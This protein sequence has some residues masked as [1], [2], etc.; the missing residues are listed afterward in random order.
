LHFQFYAVFCVF[1]EFDGLDI[2]RIVYMIDLKDNYMQYRKIINYCH[3][4]FE[5]GFSL[6]KPY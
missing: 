1:K 3:N 6:W 2:D 5:R 4:I